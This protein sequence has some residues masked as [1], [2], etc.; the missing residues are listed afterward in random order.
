[1]PSSPP[2]SLPTSPLSS[3]QPPVAQNPPF[4]IP[5]TRAPRRT[6]SRLLRNT[7]TF[8]LFD[9]T[10]DS[11]MIHSDPFSLLLLLLLLIADCVHV[12]GG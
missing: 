11:I 10:M 5:L 6:H 4:F 12:W 8:L 9:C 7:N 3:P 1:V 2:L